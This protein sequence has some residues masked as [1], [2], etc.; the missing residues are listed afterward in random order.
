MPWTASVRAA[1]SCTNAGLS[2]CFDANA[3][4]LP[5]G[6]ARF[7]SLPDTRTTEVGKISFGLASELLHR[8]VL[9]HA[10]SPD[11][12]G[13]DIRVVDDAIDSSFFVGFGLHKGIELSLATA[14]RVF[15]SGAGVGGISSQNAPPVERSA[16]R[17]PRLGLAYS[18]DDT[19]KT[20]GLG[21]RLA[22][23]AALPL[24]DQNVFA[25]ERYVVAMPSV[26]IGWQVGALGVGACLGARLRS[27]VDFA[28]VHLGDQGFTALG[29]ALDLLDPG[30]LRVSL[31][32]YGFP[33]LS[34]SRASSANAQQ[35]DSLLFPAEWLAAVHSSFDT[36]S[37][38]TLSLGAGS[39]IPLSSETA[40]DGSN[41]TTRYFFG[42]TTPQLRTLLVLRFS[43]ERSP[44]AQH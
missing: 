38:W 32:A 24:G 10:P 37:Q 16:V 30:L 43:A 26:T 9:A 27:A 35:T 31:E 21:L 5:A 2:A 22:L 36:H 42:L 28:G 6:H 8:P 41:S 44:P 14:T 40:R 39:G 17:S 20:P 4:W 11:Q 13:R 25:G 29:L 3:L 19:L 1:D 34:G 15:Q 18:L 12:N 7:L 33:P 23:D